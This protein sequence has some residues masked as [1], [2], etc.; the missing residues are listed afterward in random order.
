MAEVTADTV[1]IRDLD[2]V[3]VT[4]EI[5]QLA[6][7]AAAAIQFALN[8]V[9]PQFSG[10]GGGGLL[11]GR[12]LLVEP[13]DFV[14]KFTNTIIHI[15][16]LTYQ[17]GIFGFCSGDGGIPGVDLARRHHLGRAR[18]AQILAR[19]VTGRAALVVQVPLMGKAGIGVGINRAL[20]AKRFG[21]SNAISV[22]ASRPTPS[23]AASSRCWPSAA[24]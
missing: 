15:I 22:A 13:L 2:H 6:F 10:I 8:V 4:R 7:D 3:P 20:D 24:A 11:Q 19:F 14:S 16:S 1:T 18:P 23:P 5:A 17:H 12:A 21:I 9:E